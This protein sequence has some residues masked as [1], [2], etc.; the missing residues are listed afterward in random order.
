MKKNNTMKKKEPYRLL[1]SLPFSERDIEQA[2]ARS[3]RSKEREDVIY[4]IRFIINWD[5]VYKRKT[6]IVSKNE[7]IFFIDT[8]NIVMMFISYPEHDILEQLEV[9]STETKAITLFDSLDIKSARDWYY[10]LKKQF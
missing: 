8:A 6:F 4:P 2:I 9:C 5:E 3:K 7:V 1:Q 10:L